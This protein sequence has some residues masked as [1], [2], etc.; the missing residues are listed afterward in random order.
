MAISGLAVPEVAVIMGE[1][2]SGGAL[3]LATADRVLML[4]DAVYSVVSPESCATILWKSQ[5]RA[6]EAADALEI[7]RA[8]CRER[9][10]LYV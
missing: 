9:V 3:A 1:G 5:K 7:G 6:A 8:S 4:S 10:C 2:G